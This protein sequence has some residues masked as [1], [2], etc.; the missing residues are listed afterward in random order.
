M[1][2]VQKNQG[3][4]AKVERVQQEAK[5]TI[6]PA[7]DIFE[8]ADETWVVAD[9]PGVKKADLHVELEH[10]ELRIRATPTGFFDA[11]K[12]LEL[13][14][15]FRLPPGIDAEKVSA[16]LK[17]GVLTLKLPKPQELKPRKIDVRVA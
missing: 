14:R 13:A 7:V 8:G 6:A 10:D 16:D 17:D 5:H 9:M 4:N 15:A 1:T 3:D 12:H 2:S 11:G